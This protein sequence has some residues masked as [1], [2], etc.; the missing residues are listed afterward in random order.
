VTMLARFPEQQRRLLAA[1]GPSRQAA[2]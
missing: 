1:A 2:V